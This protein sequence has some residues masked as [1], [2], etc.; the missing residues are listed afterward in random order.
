MT[1]SES[2][3][4]GRELAKLQHDI[5][6]LWIDNGPEAAFRAVSA[7][8]APV[9]QSLVMCHVAQRARRMSPNAA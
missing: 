6:L 5:A 4:T 8:P 3:E 2:T 1:P 7:M 9:L